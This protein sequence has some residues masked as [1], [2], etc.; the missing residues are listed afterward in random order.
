MCSLWQGCSEAKWTSIHDNPISGNNPT[1]TRNDSKF[2]IL[3]L[4]LRSSITKFPWVELVI[5]G[6]ILSAT[7]FWPCPVQFVV[8]LQT[9]MT[10]TIYS[11]FL[12][13]RACLWFYRDFQS[14][15]AVVPDVIFCANHSFFKLSS[16]SSSIVK[17]SSPYPSDVI[18]YVELFG[19]WPAVKDLLLKASKYYLK[20]HSLWF[21]NKPNP[22]YPAHHLHLFCKFIIR[23]SHS[24]ASV[25]LNCDFIQ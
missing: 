19:L 1:H 6:A 10:F 12:Y 11:F 20:N 4:F 14:K 7:T 13:S 21:Q 16:P 3:D 17:H 2:I 15:I 18:F 23:C 24:P 8:Y 5:C 22:S 9:S 25:I